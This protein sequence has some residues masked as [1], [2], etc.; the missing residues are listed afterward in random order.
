MHASDSATERAFQHVRAGVLDQTY[1]SG[2]LLTEGE[3]AAA[4]GVSRTPVREALLR[5]EAQG[6]LRLYPKRGALVLPVSAREMDDVFEARELVEGFA[7]R[8]VWKTRK[9]VLPQLDDLLAAMAAARTRG[10][11]S[12]LSGA[13]R[14]FHAAIVRAAGNDVLVRL[15]DGLRDRQTCMGVAAAGLSPGW[16][17]R[18]VAEH[19]AIVAALRTGTPASLRSLVQ[20]HI[21]GARTHLRGD[22]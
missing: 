15:Y 11:A 16:M 7:A 18:A 12:A 14:D 9:A 1:P 3:V 19:T 20:E 4:V 8:K 22:R 21:S 10:D 13:D 5:L 17:D 6:L 2:S